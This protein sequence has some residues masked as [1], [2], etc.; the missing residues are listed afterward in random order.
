MT[1][2]LPT[3]DGPK[4]ARRPRSTLVQGRDYSE[5]SPEEGP[6]GAMREQNEGSRHILEAIADRNPITVNVRNG[7]SEITFGSRTIGNEMRNLASG[8]EELRAGMDMIESSASTIGVATEKVPRA[9]SKLMSI[10]EL[11]HIP[12]RL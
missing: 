9:V 2:Q 8:S 11:R 12:A 6:K 10:H 1:G 5:E 7:S 3:E 4:F